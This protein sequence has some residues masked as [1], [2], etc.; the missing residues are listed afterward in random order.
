MSQAWAQGQA[1][2]QQA[3]P[4]SA[5]SNVEQ[6]AQQ[7]KNEPLNAGLRVDLILALCQE[8]QRGQ[9]LSVLNDLQAL[10]SLP[11]GIEQLLTQL[12]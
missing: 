3:T 7:L 12:F 10:G 9:A 11:E 5:Q 2:A 1:K 8:G 4:A 6:L